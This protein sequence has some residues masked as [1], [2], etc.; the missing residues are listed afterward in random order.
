MRGSGGGG[1]SGDGAAGWERALVRAVVPMAEGG[2]R[3]GPDLAG[4][5]RFGGRRLSV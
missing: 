2:D 1:G 3:D 5:G 4:L